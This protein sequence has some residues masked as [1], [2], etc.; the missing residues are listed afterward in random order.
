M[1]LAQE[2]FN[3]IGVAA[4]RGNDTGLIMLSRATGISYSLD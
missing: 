3:L 1:I 4:N 2:E